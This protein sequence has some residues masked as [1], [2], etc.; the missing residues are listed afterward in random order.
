M[1]LGGWINLILSVGFVTVLFV[2]CLVRVLRGP[3]KDHTL[4]HIEPIE[5][6]ETDA[7]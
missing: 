6:D 7:R 3:P 5:R 2:V 1:T 4:A